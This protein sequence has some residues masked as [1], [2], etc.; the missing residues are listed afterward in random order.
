MHFQTRTTIDTLDYSGSGFNEG[1]KVVMA[2]AGPAIRQLETEVPAELKLPHELSNPA[3]CLPGVLAVSGPVWTERDDSWFDRLE[4]AIGDALD[5]RRFPLLV[6][7]DGD[8][9]VAG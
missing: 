2:A 1:S 4:H 9:S 8:A 6:V 5:C 3:V 7:V